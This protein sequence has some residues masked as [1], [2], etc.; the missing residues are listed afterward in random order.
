[1][2]ELHKFLFEGLPV[3]GMIVRLTDAWTEVQRRR[4]ANSSNGPYPQPVQALLGEM[5]AAGVLMQSNIK[6]NGSLI[7]Q[8]FGDGPV[9]VAVV[10]VQPDLS[11]RATATVQ[12][13]VG[14]EATLSQ[15]VNATN[16]LGQS[17]T[18]EL[19][20]NPAGYHNNVMQNITL[21]A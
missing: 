1:M 11:L 2:S 5:L 7:L 21:T 8:I 14:N 19:I 9:K 4:A 20:F 16:K 13:A 12:P 18:S 10:E 6:F 15:M 17:Q 3:R